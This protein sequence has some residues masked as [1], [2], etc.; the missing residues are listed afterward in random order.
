MKNQVLLCR[1]KPWPNGC[2]ILDQVATVGQTNA[3]LCNM[4]AKRRQH[5]ASVWPGRKSTGEAAGEI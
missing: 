2:N 3:T 1:V 4:V 5:V